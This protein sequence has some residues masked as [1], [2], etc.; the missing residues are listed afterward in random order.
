MSHLNR[1]ENRLIR[2]RKTISLMIGIYCRSH[3]AH[4]PLCAECQALTHYAMNRMDK[5]RFKQD[6]PTC[7]KC[8]IHCYQSKMREKI[9]AVMRFS[10]PRML[11]QHPLL[12]LWH[13]WDEWVL[14]H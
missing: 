14:T 2:E 13:Y 9:R 3:H 6:K 4:E 5:C 11:I 1:K 12:T 7:V 8:P 10:G